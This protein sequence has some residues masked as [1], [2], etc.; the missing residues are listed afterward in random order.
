MKRRK[1]EKGGESIFYDRK[2]N[3]FKVCNIQVLNPI[4]SLSPAVRM[5][6]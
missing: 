1:K 6:K 3:G 4:F 2:E 5:E